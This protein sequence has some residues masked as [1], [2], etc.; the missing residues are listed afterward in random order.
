MSHVLKNIMKKILDPVKE[1]TGRDRPQEFLP[2]P[3]PEKNVNNYT[4]PEFKIQ[5]Q[6]LFL[7]CATTYTLR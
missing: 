3:T 5:L 7:I 4:A 1:A 2:P 6:L